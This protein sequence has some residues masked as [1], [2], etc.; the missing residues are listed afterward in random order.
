MF[1]GE[2]EEIL[3]VIE[4]PQFQRIMEP[5]FRQIAKCVSSPHFQVVVG[6][7]LDIHPAP[8]LSVV[9]AIEVMTPFRFRYWNGG[10]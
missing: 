2:V 9:V 3:D 8:S 6:S 7:S 1:L 10:V 5:L 4:P